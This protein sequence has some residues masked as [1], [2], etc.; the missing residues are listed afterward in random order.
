MQNRNHII[1]THWNRVALFSIL[2]FIGSVAVAQR[3]TTK[4]QVVDI[5]SSFKPVLR[6]VSKLNISSAQL[7]VDTSKL[8]MQYAIPAQNLY[9]SYIPVPLRPL[10]YQPDTILNLGD[11]NYVKFGFGNYTTPLVSV[12]AGFGDGKKSLINLYGDYISS[13]GKIQYQDYSLL[14]LKATGSYFT[15]SHEVYGKVGLNLSEFYQYGY[16]KINYSFD[17]LDVQQHFQHVQIGVGARNTAKNDLGIFYNPSVTVN[18]F[19]FKDRAAETSI[20]IELPAEKQITEKIHAKI[21]VL[22]DFTS[23][24]TKN[25]LPNDVKVK[26]NILLISPEVK[27]TDTRFFVTTGVTPVIDNGKVAV[28]PNIWGEIKLKE[29]AFIFQAGLVGKVTKNTLQRLASFNPY[30]YTIDQQNNTRE[31]ELYGGIKSTLGKHFNFSAKVGLV[32]FKNLQL[33][34]NDTIDY[35]GF[36]IKNE[37]DANNVRVHGDI[38]YV[39]KDKFSFTAGV[40]FNGYTD[41]LIN[42]YAF[43]LIPAEINAAVRWQ[44]MKQLFLKSELW[45]FG[46]SPYQLKNNEV[47]N[48]FGGTDL[49]VGAEYKI[50]PKWSAWMD[51]NNLFSNKYQRWTNYPV[52]GINVLVGAKYSF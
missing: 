6:N 4:K 30:L 38:S 37:P 19:G 41:I 17:K 11:R 13:K 7:Q 26:N 2:T 44:A 40:T 39:N 24:N 23:Y 15:Q 34:E 22:G 5:T 32:H 35:R 18:L 43:G 21:S 52:Y 8:T 46:G 10:A 51:I 31:V 33:A 27:Y 16:D 3:D 48:T 9:Y 49:D 20:A 36:Y 29:N 47:K 14:D 1:F 45:L 12:R 50:N 25:F 42:K 28:L